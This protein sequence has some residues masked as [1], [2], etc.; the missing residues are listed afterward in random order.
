M[1]NLTNHRRRRSTRAVVAFLVFALGGCGGGGLHPVQGKL[2]Y[3]DGQPVTEL[4]GYSV[5]F[6][7][8]K[9]GKSAVGDIAEDGSFR[10]TTERPNDGALPGEYQV[11]VSQPHPNPERN[12]NRGPFVD[13]AYEDPLLSDLKATVEPKNNDFTFRLRRIKTR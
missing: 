1:T 8:E 4:A 12:Q 13:L 10:L 5:T 3:E 6:T 7:S 11:I 2:V 9:L